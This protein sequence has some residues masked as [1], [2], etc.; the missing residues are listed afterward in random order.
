MTEPE[1]VTRPVFEKDGAWY[2]QDG[3]GRVV[4]GP[5]GSKAEADRRLMQWESM[6]PDCGYDGADGLDRVGEEGR[7]SS[8]CPRCL[9][10]VYGE[11]RPRKEV[12]RLLWGTEP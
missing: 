2:V 1:I 3:S 10:V 11:D 4:F 9:T 6:C 5:F 7:G 12:F 8:V